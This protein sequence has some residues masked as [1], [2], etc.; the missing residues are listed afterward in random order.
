MGKN[1]ATA[2][3]IVTH[4]DKYGVWNNRSEANMK[5]FDIWPSFQRGESF[6]KRYLKVNKILLQLQ[7]VLPVDLW[8]LDALW[9]YLDKRDAGE[10]IF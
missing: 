6:G 2:I 4:P 1:T 7:D 8:L 9:W 10:T 3:L 5:R